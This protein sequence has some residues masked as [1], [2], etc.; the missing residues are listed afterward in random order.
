MKYLEET[1]KV[2]AS[3]E[4][5]EYLRSRIE[6]LMRTIDGTFTQEEQHLSLIDYV[7]E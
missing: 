5:P 3:F 6:N 2:L 1:R 4:L 7:R